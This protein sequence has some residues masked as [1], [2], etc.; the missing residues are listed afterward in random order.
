MIQVAAFLLASVFVGS[1]GPPI[2]GFAS[3]YN[4][5]DGTEIETTETSSG[6]TYD[7]KSWTA[8]IQIDLR[9]RFGGVRYGRN[10]KRVYAMVMCGGKRL[11][12][13]INDVGP[14]R[15]G[16]VIDLNERSMRYC[17]PS[18]RLGLV[19]VVVV[20]LGDGE[21]KTGPVA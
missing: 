13:R 18:M 15:P 3:T 9:G 4:P 17:D 2:V 14:L 11:V 20:P 1:I 5:F 21:R 6:E 10:Y 7:P 12:V 8:A 16:R 19:P